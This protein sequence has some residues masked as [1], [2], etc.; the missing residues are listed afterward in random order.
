VTF[1]GDD[2]TLVFLDRELA[3][4][5]RALVGQTWTITT[6]IQGDIASGGA[7]DPPPTVEFFDDGTFEFFTT[8]NDGEG[9][10]E[11]SGDELTLSNVEVTEAGCPSEFEQDAEEHILDVLGGGTVTWEIDAA[12][13]TIMNGDL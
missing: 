1:T 3:D 10:Y 9:E 5:D 11:E 8:C 13:L 7:Y 12:R 6:F 2:A 4:P